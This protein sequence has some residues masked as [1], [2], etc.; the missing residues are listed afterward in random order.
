MPLTNYEEF[1]FRLN[2]ALQFYLWPFPLHW[3]K[4]YSGMELNKSKLKLIP[5]KFII[6]CMFGLGLLCYSTVI[7]YTY[8]KPNPNLDMTKCLILCVFGGWAFFVFVI[9]L[10]AQNSIKAIIGF[11]GGMI[12]LGDEIMTGK[13]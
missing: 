12:K 5:F 7:Y 1:G 11:L 13:H 10:R 2:Y 3:N 4:D 9:V 8:V 6:A